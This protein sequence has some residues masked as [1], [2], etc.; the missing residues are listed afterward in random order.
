MGA[1]KEKAKC[2][3]DAADT[4]KVSARSRR[5]GD[6]TQRWTDQLANKAVG[7]YLTIQPVGPH[8]SLQARRLSNGAV[9]FYWR[10]THQGVC[11]REDIGTYDKRL[12]PKQLTPSSGGGWT[13]AAAA[14]HA[15]SLALLHDAWLDR[16]G[17]RAYV[18][19]QEQERDAQVEQQAT[20][21][22]ASL[23]A[24]VTAYWANL[25]DKG[26]NSWK[27]VRNGLT[28]HLIKAHPELSAL[29]A[30]SITTKQITN[31]LRAI[32]AKG[33][34]RQVGK[35]RA[36]LNAAFAIAA[37]VDIDAE[38]SED[39]ARFGIEANPVSATSTAA[40]PGGTDK[41]P[42]S[43]NEMRTYWQSIAHLPGI[44]GAALRLHL[45][46]GAPRIA[47]LLRLLR[48]DI[49]PDSLTLWDGK[50][51]PGSEPRAHMLPLDEQAKA[52]IALL[53]GEGRY[54]FSLDGGQSHISY[55]Q[56]RDCA[57][58][59]VGDTISGFQLKRLRSGVETLLASLEVSKDI[60]GRLQSHGISGVQD[61]HYDAHDYL[62]QKARALQLLTRALDG[63]NPRP[64][65]SGRTASVQQAPAAAARG[66]LLRSAIT[67]RSLR[68]QQRAAR[69]SAPAPAMPS[70][71][72]TSTSVHDDALSDDGAEG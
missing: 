30:K 29:P 8:G 41:R 53:C 52:D 19:A 10:Y 49:Q 67:R 17:Y 72:P 50:G 27:D 15:A 23:G 3:A 22:Q 18:Q 59:A 7:Q 37:N 70:K 58:E 71:G 45:R 14:A 20:D 9:R 5:G 34:G 65:A 64:A 21:A 33:I 16:G 56:L 55:D 36:W 48:A 47:Q 43:A 28:L 60:R 54:A 51:R 4:T 39:W 13:M 6:E 46:L 1:R 40:I 26:K 61:R 38:V 57:I 35:I 2:S 69:S 42:L 11:R 25:R 63:N 32:R 31:F 44:P 62:R 68:A 12:P 66:R 24:L